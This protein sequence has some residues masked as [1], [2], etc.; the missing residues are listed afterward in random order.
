MSD[1]RF[2]KAGDRVHIRM[3]NGRP[4]ETPYEIVSMGQGHGCLIREVS[5]VPGRQYAPQRWDTT[6][7]FKDGP[8]LLARL[9]PFGGR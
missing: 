2:F 3:D 1:T 6:L 4:G 8:E 7:L 9:F 5:S